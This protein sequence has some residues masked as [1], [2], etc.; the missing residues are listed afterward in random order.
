MEPLVQY[1]FSFFQGTCETG[2]FL[3]LAPGFHAVCSEGSELPWG[4]A[5]VEIGFY[6][7]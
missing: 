7:L 3:L 6:G 1:Y 4:D 2:L 5:D